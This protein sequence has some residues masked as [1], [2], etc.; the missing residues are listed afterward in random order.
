M[1]L[2]VVEPQAVGLESVFAAGLLKKRFTGT[3][4]T[5]LLPGHNTRLVRRRPKATAG[6]KEAD[7]P[8]ARTATM[9]RL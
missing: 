8:K 2:E 4:R 1:D 9:K 5:V 6:K 7:R 3:G